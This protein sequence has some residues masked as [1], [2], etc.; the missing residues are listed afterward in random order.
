MKHGPADMRLLVFGHSVPVAHPMPAH[1]MVESTIVCFELTDTPPSQHHAGVLD[2]VRNLSVV[3]CNE[4]LWSR[5]TRAA[6]RWGS[7]SGSSMM[8]V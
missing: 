2:R 5:T 6:H 7:M 8:P 3:W 1:P 4:I